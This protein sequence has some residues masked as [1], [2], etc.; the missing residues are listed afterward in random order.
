[1]S[2]KSQATLCKPMVCI[3]YFRVGLETQAYFHSIVMLRYSLLWP[4]SRLTA[5]PT[6][7]SIEVSCRL[8]HGSVGTNKSAADLLSS[9][10]WLCGILCYGSGSKFGMT[11]SILVR[12]HSIGTTSCANQTWPALAR[13]QIEGIDPFFAV[14]GS[15]ASKVSA[16]NSTQ[17]I[18]RTCLNSMSLWKW[19]YM[20]MFWLSRSAWSYEQCY[21]T[22]K[23]TSTSPH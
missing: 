2:Q 22:G 21:H 5:K 7:A 9:C 10:H 19:L 16:W 8:G 15:L 3:L 14:F 13:P 23:I 18:V 11:C 12:F 17:L 4:V 1:M 20:S 6:P